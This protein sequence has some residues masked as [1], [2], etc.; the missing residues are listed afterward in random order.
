M[1]LSTPYVDNVGNDDTLFYSINL[2]ET[3]R[4]ALKKENLEFVASA[5]CELKEENKQRCINFY[6]RY[7]IIWGKFHLKKIL[8]TTYIRL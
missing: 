4:K 5:K 7:T 2:I 6:V 8:F 3:I 1:Q